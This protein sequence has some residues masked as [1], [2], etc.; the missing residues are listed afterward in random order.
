MIKS[1]IL[2]FKLINSIKLVINKNHWCL[3]IW[4]IGIEKKLNYWIILFYINLYFVLIVAVF[5]FIIPRF[6]WIPIVFTFQIGIWEDFTLGHTINLLWIKL[7]ANP[8]QVHWYNDSL[9]KG[10]MIFGGLI[11]NIL[12]NIFLFI[13]RKFLRLIEVTRYLKIYIIVKDW[14]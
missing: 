3:D 4:N 9:L 13:F 14:D 5:K 12:G 7:K 1:L 8:S 6:W 11:T 10:H 2:I